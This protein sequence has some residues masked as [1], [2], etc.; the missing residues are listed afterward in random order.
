[1]AFRAQLKET[2]KYLLD[3]NCFDFLAKGG[4]VG[5]A[6]ADLNQL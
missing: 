6:S 1:M 2:E 3:G 4:E 5:V